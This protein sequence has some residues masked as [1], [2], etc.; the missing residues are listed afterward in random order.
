MDSGV[1]RRVLEHAVDCSD[2]TAVDRDYEGDLS[3]LVPDPAIAVREKRHAEALGR[4]RALAL[5]DEV[6]ADLLIVLGVGE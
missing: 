5:T 3:L 6:V 2:G 1:T 4:L